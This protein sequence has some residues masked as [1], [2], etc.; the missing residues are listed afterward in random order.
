MHNDMQLAIINNGFTSKWFTPTRGLQQGCP[1]S[2]LIFCLVVEILAIKV[3]ALAQIKGVTISNTEIKI[4]QYIDDTTLFVKDESAARTALSVTLDFG[5]ASGL[6][7]NVDK[8][9]FMW[10]GTLKNSK[11]TICDRA[12][13]D[14]VKILGA[15]FSALYPCDN[16]RPTIA[17][18][19]TV[20]NQWSQKIY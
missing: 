19:E 7:L 3:R 12:C 15:N 8:C 6:Q 13:S 9:H 2:S 11:E 10:L 5:Y 18:M 17:S 16:V 20:I 1:A 4:S 14:Q